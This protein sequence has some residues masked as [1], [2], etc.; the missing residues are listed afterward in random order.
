MFMFAAVAWKSHTNSTP[1]GV[2]WNIRD[3]VIWHLFSAKCRLRFRHICLSVENL[4]SNASVLDGRG[5]TFAV[6][7]CNLPVTVPASAQLFALRG[8]RP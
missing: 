1:F 8:G 2:S 4:S 7:H 5:C 6:E 3:P